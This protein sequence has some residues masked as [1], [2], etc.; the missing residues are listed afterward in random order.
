MS[1]IK[2]A[3]CF[4]TVVAMASA[5]ATRV[6]ADKE[7]S[8]E[9]IASVTE[10]PA[11]ARATVEKL[12]AGGHIKSIL[13]EDEDGKTVFD[14]E[15][16]VKGNDVEYSVDAD[17][18]IITS[19]ESVEFNSLPAA[20]RAA[21]EKDFGGTVDLKAGKETEAGKTFFEV[22]HEKN[23]KKMTVKYDEAGKQVEEEKN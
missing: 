20:V 14:V 12:T 8:D 9:K 2:F 11:A 15:A 4:V 16:A 17:G 19:E 5:S 22:E 13:K 1:R 7:K 6:R 23:G 18:K 21:A 3:L 10:L